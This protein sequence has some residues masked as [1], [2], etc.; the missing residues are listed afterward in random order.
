[1]SLQRKFA[2]LL[3]LIG[4]TVAVNLGTTFWA[5]WLLDRELSAPL[6]SVATALRSLHAIKLAAGRQ[7]QMLTVTDRG[8]AEARS[9]SLEKFGED[10]KRIVAEIDTLR[11]AFQM[12]S[13]IS[14]TLN[15]SQRA[16]RAA[17][18][19]GTWF[20]DGDEEARRA[21][22]EELSRVRELV[23]RIES[24]IL[25]EAHVE[26]GLGAW[27]RARVVV[28]TSACLMMVLLAG[29]LGAQLVRRW[30]LRPVASLRDAAGRIAAGD[31]AHR[32]PVVGGDEIALLS[33][34]VN[35]MAGMVA[36]MQEERVERERLAAVGEMT[37]RIAHNLRSPLA[38]IR[39]LAELSRA[40]L[41]AGSELRENQ[42]RIVTTLDRFERWV[43][44]LLTAASPLEIRSEMAEV[45]G[46]IGGI[47]ESHRALAQARGV[48]IEV[49][50]SAAPARAMFD[51]RHLEHA[52]VAIL[53]NAIDAAPPGTVVRVGVRTCEDG[54]FWE[55]RVVDQGMG[56]AA[57]LLERIFRPYFTTKKTGTG[58]GLA[59]AQRV[60]EQHAGQ[61]RVRSPAEPSAAKG[62][63]GENPGSGPGAAFTVHLPL[64]GGTQTG[65]V[66]GPGEIGSPTSATFLAAGGQDGACVGQDS[67]HRGRREPAVLDR[68]RP[69]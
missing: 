21:A 42:D 58:I 8:G 10:S 61:I 63:K 45:P 39:G 56:V 29:V 9:G 14:T 57:D 59:V 64:R 13:G 27:F 7:G 15:L 20:T 5:A 40:E 37:R 67:H 17:Q 22:G 66:G 60:V 55:I 53:S 36:A 33:G 6:G 16:V 12:R 19:A 51:A 46:W 2:L 4:L 32:V 69:D 47:V 31:F 38:G 1:M 41:P 65:T 34:E 52:I 11:K 24:Q 50:V 18:E 35:H 43:A 28:V 26:V 44:D 25:T 54:Q 62:G 68:S 3:G 48:G 49:D 30:V 23:D